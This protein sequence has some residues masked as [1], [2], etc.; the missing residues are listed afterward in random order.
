LATM[1]K[2]KSHQSGELSLG[3]MASD[4]AGTRANLSDPLDTL[5]GMAKSKSHRSG[6][7]SRDDIVGDIGSDEAG[8][9]GNL[10]SSRKTVGEGG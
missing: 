7:Q 3:G 2:S 1:A 10:G 9:R 4:E 5:A 6:E 8:A